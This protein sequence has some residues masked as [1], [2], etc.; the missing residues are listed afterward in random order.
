MNKNRSTDVLKPANGLD[1][2]EDTNFNKL[3]SVCPVFLDL[4][5]NGQS[6]MYWQLT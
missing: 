1:F 2:V 4:S 5:N 3:M 6:D